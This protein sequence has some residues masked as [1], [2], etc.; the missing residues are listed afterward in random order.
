MRSVVGLATA[1]CVSAI[2][3]GQSSAA[4]IDDVRSYLDRFYVAFHG[5][6][7][8][9]GQATDDVTSGAGSGR[10]V[11]EGLLGHRFGGAI[12][13]ILNPYVAL[14]AEVSYNKA[15][16]DS[17]SLVSGP[18]SP[19]SSSASGSI[20]ATTYIAKVLLGPQSGHWRP[21]IGGGIGV[22]DFSLKDLA[23]TALPSATLSGSDLGLALQAI[24]GI[25]YAIS[26]R[27]T[28]GGRY[29]FLHL[30]EIL[31]S[32]PIVLTNQVASE[33]HSAEFVLTVH[34]GN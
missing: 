2:P 14:E 22:A 23:A 1:V 20:S 34:L 27:V 16:I 31:F 33:T 19:A 8:V 11:I 4:N 24:A 29:R 6:G 10:L 3:F 15:E 28:V 17:L 12:G 18:G 21:Y 26:D 5:G 9:S 30:S 25:N 7:I 32:H 13:Y